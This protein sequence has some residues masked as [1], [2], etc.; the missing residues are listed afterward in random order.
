MI[1]DAGPLS[2][3]TLSDLAIRAAVEL[4]RRTAGQ[5]SDVCIFDELARA[6][7]RTSEPVSN[8]AAFHFIEPGYFSPFEWLYRHQESRQ[9][10]KVEDIQAFIKKT[11]EAL[12]HVERGDQAGASEL[13]NFCLALHQALIQE[14]TAEGGFVVHNG[15]QRDSA[16]EVGFSPA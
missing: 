3:L 6:L 7:R 5:P 12:E 15:G 9:S 13:Q 1:T 8:A 11:S 10:G 4:D 14:L 2:V 16:A